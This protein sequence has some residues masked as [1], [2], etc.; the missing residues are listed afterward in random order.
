MPREKRL[1][2]SPSETTV[3]DAI[4]AFVAARHPDLASGAV[5][6][7]TSLGG[8]DILDSRTVRDLVMDLGER[9]GVPIGEE[10]LAPSS[11]DSVDALARA[12]DARRVQL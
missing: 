4:L 9:F 7:A 11:F 10:T 12:I 8:G 5:T 6:G 1:L 2:L 3:R